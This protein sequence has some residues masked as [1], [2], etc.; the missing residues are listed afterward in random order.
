[1]NE[2]LPVARRDEI[3]QR[4]GQGQAVVANALAVEFGVSEDAIRRDLRALAAQGRCRR[5]YGGAL[6]LLPA[7][8]P[9]TA[10]IDESRE[11]KAALARAALPLIQRGELL[12]LDSGSTNLALVALLP[13]D[14]E[15]TVATNSIDIAAAVLRR[16][17]LQL[18]MVGGAVDL[19]VGGCID[20]TAIQSVTQMN[21]DH[22]LVGACA[23]SPANGISVFAIADATFKRAVLAASRHSIVLALSDKFA[24]HASHRVATIKQIDHVIVEHDIPR[25]QHAAFSLAG[26]SVLKAEAPGNA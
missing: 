14:F 19:A 16:S 18:I 25:A 26:T 17:D 7:T 1:M 3:A 2:E 22:C 6:P 9:M 10:R 24:A 23:I 12:F 15:L 11:R 13:E 21:F 20:A 8:V 5:V 4:L